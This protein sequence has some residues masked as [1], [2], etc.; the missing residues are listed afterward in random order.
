MHPMGRRGLIEAIAGPADIEHY[1]FGYEPGFPDRLAD[2]VLAC[3]GDD[4][5]SASSLR[6]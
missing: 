4:R 1:A 6:S 5:T 3:A 2:D